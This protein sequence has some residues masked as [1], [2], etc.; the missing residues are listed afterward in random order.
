MSQI[1]LLLT[2]IFEKELARREINKK[3]K[4]NKPSQGNLKRVVNKSSI[5]L[6]LFLHQ[7][8]KDFAFTSLNLYGF[9]SDYTKERQTLSNFD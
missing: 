3:D 6:D 9:R 1:K 8:S 5:Y 2:Y 7:R 4:C